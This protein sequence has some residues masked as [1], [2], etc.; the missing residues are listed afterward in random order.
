MNLI[1]K[2]ISFT[3]FLF[4]FSLFFISLS[5]RAAETPKIPLDDIRTI[6]ET[7]S[8]IKANYAGE[9]DDA[10]LL[11]SCIAGMVKG[12]DAD[13]SY[14]TK[15]RFHALRD[16]VPSSKGGIGLTLTIKNGFPTVISPIEGS[17]SQQAGLRSGDI[18]LEVDG[19][20]M[21]GI[22]LD[23]VVERLRG[24]I[25]EEIKLKVVSDNHKDI[26]LFKLKRRFIRIQSVHKKLLGNN[27]AYIRISAFMNNTSNKLKSNINKLLRQAKGGLKG[28]I[29]DLR[30]NPG[31]LLNEAIAVADIFLDEGLIAYTESKIPN[32]E[33][34]FTAKDNAMLK[35][36]PIVIL[37]NKGSAAAS[38]IVSGA[39]KDHK[40]ATVIGVRTFGSG[41]V[42][43]IMPLQ[44]GGALKLTTSRWRTP[45]GQYI[46]G[47][48]IEP[49][50]VL[51]SGEANYNN[52]PVKR[53]VKYI[54]QY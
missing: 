47:R 7:Y 17:P 33:L 48:G 2:K 4:S 20:S 52:F 39:L 45:N 37:V 16:G 1:I 40:R 13:S 26:Q 21:Q 50:I 6:S 28:L 27:I 35:G 36:L 10:T 54:R 49:D 42:Q 53:A 44:N 9:V 19:M 51:N 15:K 24:D 11:Q 23:D 34:R 12:A 25:G 8:R 30:N 32:L 38:E 3:I 31:G 29:L 18:V 22:S 41:S 5:S 14:L 43:T 46:H